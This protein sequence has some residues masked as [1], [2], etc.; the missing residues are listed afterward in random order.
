MEFNVN[1]YQILKDELCADLK[2]KVKAPQDRERFL[3]EVSRLREYFK[4]APSLVDRY[5]GHKRKI[6]EDTYFS[7]CGMLISVFIIVFFLGIYYCIFS[8]YSKFTQTS[9]VKNSLQVT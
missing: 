4:S 6:E 3:E 8:W 7:G 9:Q 1:N 2:P 5:F